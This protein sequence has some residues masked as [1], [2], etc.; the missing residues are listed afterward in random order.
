MNN[1]I[2]KRKSETCGS[3]YKNAFSQPLLMAKQEVELVY[4]AKRGDVVALQKIYSSSLR[5]IVSVAKQYQNGGWT[6]EQLI[7]VGK[8]GII[9]AL[10]MY[11]PQ[12]GA[13]FIAYAVW[14]IRESITTELSTA[15]K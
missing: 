11:E 4:S 8:K 10:R 13:R 6:L 2:N 9:Q 5:F 12:R 14:H 1:N 15:G 7:E 3:N